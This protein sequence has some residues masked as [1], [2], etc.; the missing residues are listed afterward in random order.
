MVAILKEVSRFFLPQTPK[1]EASIFQ[2]PIFQ[3]ICDYA[4]SW[5]SSRPTVKTIALKE[6]KRLRDSIKA[7]KKMITTVGEYGKDCLVNGVFTG[8]DA[9]AGVRDLCKLLY[10]ATS[11]VVQKLAHPVIVLGIF[12]G[13]I[14]LL[15]GLTGV[16]ASSKIQDNEGVR[17][18]IMDLLQGVENGVGSALWGV[19]EWIPALGASP[20]GAVLSSFVTPLFL[21]ASAINYLVALNNLVISEIFHERLMRCLL[22]NKNISPE[23]K[24]QDK[25]NLTNYFKGLLELST[26]EEKKIEQAVDSPLNKK[27]LEI[28][29]RIFH[30]K[31]TP[32]EMR[33]KDLEGRTANAIAVK[34]N[35][36][37]RRTSGECGD[38]VLTNLKDWKNGLVG[39][40]SLETALAT[41]KSTIFWNRIF[42]ALKMTVVAAG[43]AATIALLFCPQGHI[44]IFAV[45]VTVGVLWMVLDTRSTL[46]WKK[47]DLWEKARKSIVGAKQSL[48]EGADKFFALSRN[49]S[50][51]GEMQSLKERA[52]KFLAFFAM[53][54]RRASYETL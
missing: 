26:E 2:N 46:I 4:K 31:K 14:Q 12:Q 44:A 7:S 35:A 5:F 9:A 3:K 34:R 32:D 16:Y 36:F 21:G 38:I 50:S 1:E 6:M 51:V 25:A 10:G 45:A 18:S 47:L 29:R 17:G 19:T 42:L 52:G 22:N 8:T 15:Q 23:H 49:N 24:D 13:L 48:E 37:E 39:K 53:D 11:S 20:V 43:M 27:W 30:S 41:I 28:K 54:N 40:T 33:T